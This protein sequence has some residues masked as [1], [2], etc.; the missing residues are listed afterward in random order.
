MAASTNVNGFAERILNNLN[1]VAQMVNDEA[2][3]IMN[4]IRIRRTAYCARDAC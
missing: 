2:I 1:K 3:P 4:I